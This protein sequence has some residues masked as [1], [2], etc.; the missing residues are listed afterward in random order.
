M[1]IEMTL[2][3]QLPL[4]IMAYGAEI[5]RANPAC[6]IFCI[7]QSGSMN[8]SWSASTKTKKSEKVAEVIN[9]LLYNHSIKCASGTKVRDYFYVGVIGYNNLNVGSLLEIPNQTEELLPIS[10]IA[11]NPLKIEEREKKID[12]GAGGLISVKEKFPVWIKPSAFGDTPMCAAL[13]EARYYCQ[14][15][16]D[17]HPASFPPIVINITDGESNDGDPT[18]NAKLIR[19]IQSKDGHALLFNIHISSIKSDPI[20][21]PDSTD[22]L[23]DEFAVI[24][25]NM[26]SVLTPDMRQHARRLGFNNITENSRGY[27][28][29]SDYIKFVEFLEIGTGIRNS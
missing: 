17:E 6:F 24:L 28:F 19:E 10:V 23:P 25:F 4:C 7:D 16:V 21:F 11:Q 8:D 26:S 1:C 9:R 13:D 14:K 2:I 3:K 5:S 15:W 20:V 22:I 27:G 29:N 18:S 12:D